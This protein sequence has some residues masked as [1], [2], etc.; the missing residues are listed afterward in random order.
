MTDRITFSGCR[1]DCDGVIEIGLTGAHFNGNGEALDD[2]VGALADDVNAD[3]SF[4]WTVYNEF[5]GCRLLVGFVD[6]AKVERLEG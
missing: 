2:L 6:H 5:E 4:F 3:D 1:V